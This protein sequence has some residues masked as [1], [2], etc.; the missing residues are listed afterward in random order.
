MISL[1]KRTS[2]VSAVFM[3]LMM[4]FGAFG[5][6]ATPVFAD[7]EGTTTET[8]TAEAADNEA[9]DAAGIVP[10]S[11]SVETSFTDTSGHWAESAVKRWSANGVLT[12]YEDSTFNPNG[13]ITR[14]EFAVI[15]DR[16]MKYQT[17]APNRFSDLGSAFY[18]DAIL[19]A[20]AAD[21]MRGYGST[22]R[23]SGF[24]TREEVAVILG[25]AFG[26]TE[27][28]GGSSFDDA[29][30]IASWSNGFV[31]ALV[32]KGYIRGS[33]GVFRPKANITRAE[34]AQIL[35]NAVSGFY[36]APG[37]YTANAENIVII[38]TGGVTLESLNIGDSVIVAEGAGSGE[39][40]LEN[41]KVGNKTIIR[42]GSTVT[43]RGS[44]GAVSVDAPATV[45]FVG[46]TAD[47][48]DVDAADAGISLDSASKATTVTLES[49]AKNVSIVNAGAIDTL[50]IEAGA[51]GA[52][53]SGNGS[54]TTRNDKSEDAGATDSIR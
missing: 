46:A 9:A 2:S 50:N 29:S 52:D 17:M 15:I 22:V 35:S 7:D 54:V 28:T 11:A 8:E 13:P 23:P 45:S 16:I 19:K 51:T 10:I 4:A 43:L 42:G 39:V 44:F 25:R 31:T 3:A 32:Q 18:T 53:V 20:N 24:I 33:D 34:V 47:S 49:A 26:L 5:F 14:G 21:I 40:T 36:N 38:N 1:K 48:V 12:G 27:A 37:A 30:Q 41:V 6:A